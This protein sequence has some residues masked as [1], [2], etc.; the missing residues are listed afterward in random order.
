[1]ICKQHHTQDF[2]MGVQTHPPADPGEVQSPNAFLTI[3]IT[4]FY[5]PQ[6]K[7]TNIIIHRKKNNKAERQT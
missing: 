1:M 6:H 5:H 3:K 7:H 4:N 2:A